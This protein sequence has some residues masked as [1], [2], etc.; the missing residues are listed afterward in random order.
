MT[1]RGAV[2]LFIVRETIDHAPGGRFGLF[3]INPDRYL[4]DGS[5]YY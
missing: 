3:T 4:V 5:V 2:A 1:L